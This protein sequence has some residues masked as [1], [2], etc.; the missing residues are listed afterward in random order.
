[1]WILF[2]PEVMSLAP[3]LLDLLWLELLGMVVCG[4]VEGYGEVY[5]SDL[6]SPDRPALRLV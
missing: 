5:H 1:M 3:I 2:V 4:I 6:W